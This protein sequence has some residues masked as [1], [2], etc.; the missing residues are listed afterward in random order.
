MIQLLIIIMTLTFGPVGAMADIY[1]WV[2][3]DGVKHFSNRP[4]P[5]GTPSVRVIEELQSPDETAPDAATASADDEIL[6]TAESNNLPGDTSPISDTENRNEAEIL[7]SRERLSLVKK[8]EPLY[9]RLD[10]AEKARSKD[11]TYDFQERSEQIEQLKS[12]I[13]VEIRN[14]DDRIQQIKSQFGVE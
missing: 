5:S 13:G 12:R 14:S 2:D 11:S 8:L 1:S 4:P 9:E 10:I 7:I 6:L 3:A